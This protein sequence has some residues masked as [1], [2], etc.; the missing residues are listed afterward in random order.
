M[1]NIPLMIGQGIQVALT[2]ADEKYLP[3]LFWVVQYFQK[4]GIS[5]EEIIKTIT[6][7]PAKIFGVDDRIGSIAEGKDADIL[8]FKR[9]TG[10]PLPVLKK[11]MSEGYIVNEEK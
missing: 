8:F 3:D 9:E 10:V 1:K 6:I 4:Y 5:V 11:V 7:N 2:S